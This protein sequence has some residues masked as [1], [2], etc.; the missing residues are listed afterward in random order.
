MLN[1]PAAHDVMVVQSWPLS[2]LS[3]NSQQFELRDREHGGART[4]LVLMDALLNSVQMN[5]K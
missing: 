5:L 4:V 2:S 1:Q 3:R